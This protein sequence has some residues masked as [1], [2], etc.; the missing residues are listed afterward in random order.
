MLG[1]NGMTV[2]APVKAAGRSQRYA[3][4]DNLK[5]LMVAAVIIAH[6]MMAWTG[7]GTWVFREGPVREPLL[8]V[9]SLLTV[10]GGLYGLAL[11]FVIAGMFTPR[12]LRRKGTGRFLLDR[13]IRLG[14]PMLFFV[15]VLSP[16]VEYADPD[17]A[18]WDRGFAAFAVHTWWPPA[19]GPTWF[20]GVLLL[21]SFAYAAFRAVR[22][23]P[24]SRRG[25][26]TVRH[27]VMMAAA[28]AA[29][30]YVVRLGV[31][32]A[33]E[34]W[35]LALGQAPAWA[36]A[37][38]FGVVGGERGW[39]DSLSPAVVRASRRLVIVPLACLVPVV[40]FVVVTHGA[41]EAFLGG[42]T[43][44]SLLVAVVEGIVLISLSL[45]LLDVFRRRYNH[46]GRL[47]R[48]MSRAA[49]AAFILHQIVLVGLVLATREVSWP[50]EMDFLAV[51][52]LGVTVSFGIG[53]LLARLPGVRRVV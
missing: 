35:H 19:P 8:S 53:S 14:V 31:P 48:E 50:P 18:G 32:L 45:W 17:A 29:A 5:T 37:F 44:Q 36:G 34:R 3:Y 30:S 27:I 26:L 4:A 21:F 24:A 1:M 47:A 46:Q 52:V 2:H 49:Y 23:E 39:F 22:P 43:W 20:L 7:V 10:V 42:G 11:F 15:I 9:L 33:E 40:L 13:T 51:A 16:F 6:V 12:S 25:P 41:P 38:T 28:I